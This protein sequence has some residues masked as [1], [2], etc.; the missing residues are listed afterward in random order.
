MSCDLWGQRPATVLKATMVAW[1]IHWASV[2]SS[3]HDHQAARV[4]R[5]VNER[6]SVEDGSMGAVA[7]LRGTVGN[8][9]A[10]TLSLRGIYSSGFGEWHWKGHGVR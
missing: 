5:Q 9:K 4:A 3:G 8:G 7:S 2:P 10:S 1:E 6:H